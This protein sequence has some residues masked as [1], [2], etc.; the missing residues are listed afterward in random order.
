MLPTPNGRR[1]CGYARIELEALVQG[2]SA[3]SRATLIATCLFEN[4]ALHGCE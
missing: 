1:R 4:G 2:P 3:A